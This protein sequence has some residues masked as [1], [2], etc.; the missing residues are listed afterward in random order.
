MSNRG[1]KRWACAELDRQGKK[2]GNTTQVWYDG[3]PMCRVHREKASGNPIPGAFQKAPGATSKDPLLVM[4]ETLPY[5][6]DVGE[7]VRLS[8]AIL[9]ERRKREAGCPTCKA[10]VEDERILHDEHQFIVAR[11]TAE[12]R[13]EIARLRRALWQVL[14][15]A[16][17]RKTPVAEEATVDAITRSDGE[18]IVVDPAHDLYVPTPGTTKAAMPQEIDDEEDIEEEDIDPLTTP[19]EYWDDES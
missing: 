4:E 12:Q 7:K 13:A 16:A 9:A 15:V 10:R 6:K 14:D 1:N 2:C 3:R 19:P 5:V 17:K 11:L 18:V 8:E